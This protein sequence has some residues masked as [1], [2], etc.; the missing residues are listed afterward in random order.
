MENPDPKERIIKAAQEIFADK[1]FKSTTIREICKEADVSLALVNYHFRN[2]QSLYE[3][4]ITYSTE[5]AFFANPPEKYLSEDM[6]PEE[7][8][9]NFIRM[10]MH[11]LFGENG[12]GSSPSSV[13]LLARELTSP[14]PVMEKIYADHLSKMI[15]LMREIVGELISGVDLTDS[16]RFASS[17]AGQCLHPL[18][19]RE[20]L[21]HSGFSMDSSSESI[22]RH[23]E[24]IYR[25]SLYGIKGYKGVK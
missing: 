1:G 10:L 23:A 20:I 24:H 25:F 13:K 7:K 2:K 12:L 5:K 11:I 22:E 14:T 8:L 4:I 9:R 19:A 18:L 16:V 6:T 21:A 3:Q 17:I 15:G